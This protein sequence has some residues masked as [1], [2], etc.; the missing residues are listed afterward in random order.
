MKG[1]QLLDQS[2]FHAIARHT[3]DPTE[4]H[5][6]AVAQLIELAGLGAQH[7]SKVIRRVAFHDGALPRKSFNEESSTHARI[8][9]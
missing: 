1:G 8:L 2:E 7:A 6:F 9:S 3:L 5:A 4:P